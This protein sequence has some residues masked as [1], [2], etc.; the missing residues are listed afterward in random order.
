[1]LL[2]G[3]LVHGQH[4]ERSMDLATSVPKEIYDIP[5]ELSGSQCD[6]RHC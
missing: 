5:A 1:M 6:L 2:S 4:A 3:D